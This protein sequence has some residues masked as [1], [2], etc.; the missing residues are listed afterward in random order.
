MKK[1]YSFRL[2]Q[3]LI[4]QLDEFTGSR[5]ANIEQAIQV[6]VNKDTKEIQNNTNDIQYYQQQNQHLLNMVQ[7]LTNKLMI[8]NMSWIKRKL[9]GTK[10][11]SEK[12]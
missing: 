4:K 5:T 11:G 10:K 3:Q 9:L 8:S 2:D 12:I 7:D 6:Y 1:Q